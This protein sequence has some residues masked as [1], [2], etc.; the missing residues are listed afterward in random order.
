M[1]TRRANGRNFR[2]GLASASPTDKLKNVKVKTMTGAKL[3]ALAS[4]S[5]ITNDTDQDSQQ[6]Q[7]DYLDQASDLQSTI[8]NLS[9][10]KGGLPHPSSVGMYYKATNAGEVTVHYANNIYSGISTTPAVDGTD[11]FNGMLEIRGLQVANNT[12]SDTTVNIYLTGY[13]GDGVYSTQSYFMLFTG[14]IAGNSQ[15]QFNL[16]DFFGGPLLMQSNRIALVTQV[17]GSQAV[18]T[19]ML[20]GVVSY[21]GAFGG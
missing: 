14:T 3:K 9:T 5:F 10:Y 20:Y 16:C 17:T 4:D 12:S 21:N 19:S 15:K 2:Q 11:N 7:S 18:V 1:N 13:P 8:E 6:A